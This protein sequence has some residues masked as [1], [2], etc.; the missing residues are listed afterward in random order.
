M[1]PRT[2]LS[3]GT[4]PE[5]AHVGGADTLGTQYYTETLYVVV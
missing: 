3:G 4:Q 1:E 5:D 2:A